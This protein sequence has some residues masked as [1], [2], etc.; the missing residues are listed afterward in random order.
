MQKAMKKR[1]KK[2]KGFTL[3]ELLVVVAIIG[4]LA[5]IAIPQ[6]AAYRQRGYNA[7][8]Q[9]DARNAAT[10]QEAYFVDNAA[11]ATSCAALPGFNPSGQ[12]NCATATK[13]CPGTG[14]AGFTVTTTMAAPGL[15]SYT[16]CTWDSCGQTCANGQTGNLCCS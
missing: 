5:A 4:I 15:A 2:A 12:V 10:G 8:M 1:R 14:A 7:R 13:T 11:Y 9:A 16:R 3:I 6:F